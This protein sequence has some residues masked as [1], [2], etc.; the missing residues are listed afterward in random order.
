MVDIA[1]AL[2]RLNQVTSTL[3]GVDKL[4]VL[5]HDNPDPDSMAS[6]AALQYLIESNVL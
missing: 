2:E 6:A 4:L 3:D 5:T 1:K